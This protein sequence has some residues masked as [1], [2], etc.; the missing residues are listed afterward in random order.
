MFDINVSIPDLNA[1]KYTPE[2][3][4]ARLKNYLYELNDCLSFALSSIDTTNLSAALQSSVTAGKANAAI[5]KKL[6]EEQL[7]RFSVLKSEII[8][9]A[10]EL[11]E[12]YE[13]AVEKTEREILETAKGTYTAKS[14][15][16]EYRDTT[17]TALRQNA[18]SISLESKK[19]EELENALDEYKKSN[20]ALLQVTSDAIISAVE[21]RFVSKTELG[22]EVETLSAQITETAQGVTEVYA[23][24]SALS[25]KIAEAEAGVNSYVSEMNAYIRRGELSEGVYGIEI[26]R[27]DSLIKARFTNERLSFYQG[28]AEVAYISGSNLYITRAEVLDYLRVGNS[29]EGYFTFDATGNGL[30][31]RWNE[32]V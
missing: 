25:E 9:T 23:K 7:E 13:T 32:S 6:K 8:R 11:T 1:E 29:V 15:F 31:V 3:K 4:F 5:T 21:D 22:D 19:A 30:E 24:S 10:S 16:G 18:D 17:D 20:S 12:S 28:S 27:S 26:G 14:D 2:E